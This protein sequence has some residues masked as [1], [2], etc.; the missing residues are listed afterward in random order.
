MPPVLSWPSQR[1][2]LQRALLLF[3]A[4]PLISAAVRAQSYEHS[5]IYQKIAAPPAGAID[6]WHPTANDVTVNITM[7]NVGSI[8]NEAMHVDGSNGQEI[9]H[10]IIEETKNNIAFAYDLLVQPIEGSQ[11]VRCTFKP[12]APDTFP[13]SMKFPHMPISDSLEPVVIDNGGTIAISMIP[14]PDKKQ[15]LVQYLQ[16]QL[17]KPGT[18]DAAKTHISAST[19]QSRR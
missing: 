12:Q 18:S 11:Q 8:W 13:Q 4:L 15:K 16:M 6:R 1:P 5:P 3:V 17:R 10:L 9:I 19:L 14:D 7:T 2:F